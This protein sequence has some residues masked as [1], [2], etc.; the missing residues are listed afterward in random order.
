MRMVN[1]EPQYRDL[2]PVTVRSSTEDTKAFGCGAGGNNFIHVDPHGNLLACP[3]LSMSTGNVV[4]DGFDV[5]MRRMREL[6]PHATA[7]G[8]E[9]P[10][11]LLRDPIHEAK[12]RT[13]KSVLPYEETQRIAAHFKTTPRPLL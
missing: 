12:T 13:G 11:N 10:G 3:M 4:K 1:T 2:P 5:A 7:H 8:P 9:C 6:F